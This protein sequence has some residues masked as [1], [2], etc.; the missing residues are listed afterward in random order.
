MFIL[1]TMLSKFIADE[2]HLIAPKPFVHQLVLYY[3]LE[4]ISL[5]LSSSFYRVR[6]SAPDGSS[7]RVYSR[8]F[9]RV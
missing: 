1:S 9:F 2:I 4:L 5:L 6:D 8:F 3:R 7:P